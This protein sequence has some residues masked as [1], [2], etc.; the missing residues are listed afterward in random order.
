MSPLLIGPGIQPDQ[1]N[2]YLF[3]ECL[4]AIAAYGPTL[5]FT[6]TVLQMMEKIKMGTLQL[7]YDTTTIN[8]TIN[9]IPFL[10]L[11]TG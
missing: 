1:L 2:Q 9:C 11:S 5:M 3:G 10:I 8:V 7:H 6:G 4:D